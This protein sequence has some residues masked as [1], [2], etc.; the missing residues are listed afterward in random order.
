MSTKHFTR[1]VRFVSTDKKIYYGDAILPAGT[2]DARLAKEAFIITGNPLAEYTVT[3]QRAAIVRLLS[4]LDPAAVGTARFLGLNYRKHAEELGLPIPKYP[5]LFFK[6]RTALGGPNDAIVVP[7]IAQV[8]N[9]TDYECELV[10]VIGKPAR[11]V[12]LEKALDYVLGYAVGNDVSQRAWQIKKSGGQWGLGKM[13]DGWAPFGPAIVS[14]DLIRDPQALKISTTIN[15]KTV[16]SES[17]G[18]MIFSVA[19]AISFLSQGSTLQPGDL[20]FTGTPSGVGSGRKPNLWLQD[21]D[22]VV[23]ELENVGTVSNTVIYEKGLLPKL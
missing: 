13:Y 7:R 18:D 11:D 16:Q 2:S 14:S 17:T 22:Q 5:V 9:E 20:I 12:P 19:Q 8:D 6:P 3:S 1:L 23:V 21:G 10:A 4:P 15:G